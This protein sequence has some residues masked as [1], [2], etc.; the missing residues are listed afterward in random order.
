MNSIPLISI[1]TI[2]YNASATIEPT[3]VS[4][5]S[6]TFTDF[7]HIVVDGASSDETLAIA[8]RFADV[9]ILSERDNGLYDAMN[10]GIALAK[11]KYLLF[12]NAG[13]TFHNDKVLEIYAERAMKGD[14]IIYGDTVIVDSQRHII[15]KRHLTAPVSLTFDSFSKGM[16]ICHQAFMVRKEIAPQY[17]LKYRFSADYD[18][19]VKCIQ[20]ADSRK[21]TN[22]NVIAI[23]YLSDGLT[24][25]NKYKSLR[26]RYHI[27]SEHY[28]KTRTFFNHIGFVFRAIG[29]KLHN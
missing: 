13:D 11:G 20:R 4:V 3:L 12:L 28:G 7:E 21:C 27:M 18:W 26:E 6:Q 5:A 24:D 19:T 17:D 8:R 25:K 10:K 16:L 1:V 14:D 23:D 15:G 29:R 9:R 22:L 2:T